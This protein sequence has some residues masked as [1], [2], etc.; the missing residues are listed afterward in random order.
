[1]LD[2]AATVNRDC[3]DRV[4]DWREE[5]RRLEPDLPNLPPAARAAVEATLQR[6]LGEDAEAGSEPAAEP[7]LAIRDVLHAA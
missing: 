6:F 7:A 4:L 3:R 1:V 2:D 5:L